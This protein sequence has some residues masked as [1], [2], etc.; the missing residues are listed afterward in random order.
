VGS[1]LVEA[2]LAQ[3]YQVRCLVR[4]TSDVSFIAGLPVDLAYGDLGGA[5]GLE[6]ACRDVLAVFH[7]AGA[8]RA[9]DAQTLFEV[10]EQGTATLLEVC[11]RASPDLKRFV[12][13]S[14]LAAGG[15][16]TGTMPI[17]ETWPE[18]PVSVY[19]ASKLAGEERVRAYAGRLPVVIL[20]PAPVY[21]PRDRDI[22]TYFRL[23]G[24]GLSLVPGGKPRRVSLIYVSDVVQLALRVLEDDRSVGQTY[25]ACDGKAHDLDAVLECIAL[26]LGRRTVRA[27][28]PMRMLEGIAA[29]GAASARL[30]KRPIL[31][32]RD[33]LR[34]MRHPCWLCDSSK[35]QREL[36][37]AAL[38][39]LHSGIAR[40]AEWYRQEGWL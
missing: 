20:R 6:E 28:V 37:F 24:R 33:K 39:D 15:P 5:T 27:A 3:G 34:E 1:H 17:D 8:T 21:G 19:G 12:Y 25:F 31:L 32:N 2:L 11:G 23:V 9:L 26:V 40:T 4:P 10:N 16:S 7:L 35:A 18:R 38:V 22:L 29:L 36:G 14:S 13:L 30:L